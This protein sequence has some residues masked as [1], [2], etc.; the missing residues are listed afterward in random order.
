MSR[1]GLALAV[2]AALAALYVSRLD[3]TAG[4]YVDDAYYVVLAQAI[5]GGHGYTL[6]NSAVGPIL[7]A[8]PPGFALLLA[9][10][11]A[12]TAEF[13]RNIAALKMLSIVAMLGVAALTY[14]YL[15]D[16]R[17]L[18]RFRAAAIAVITAMLPAFVFLAT[19]TLMAECVFTLA[20]VASVVAI[21]RA[22]S[23]D[24]HTRGLIVAAVISTASWLVRSAGIAAVITGVVVLLWRRGW[25][26]SAAFLAVCVLCYAPWAIY[27]RV[28]E[29]TE[30]Q[31]AAYGGSIAY[32]Y[33][34]LLSMR[35]GGDAAGGS[36]DGGDLAARILKNAV[37]VFGR[38]FGAIFLPSGYRGAGESGQEVF[39]L[40]GES[41]LRSGSMGLGTTVLV[42][43]SMLSAFAL[44]GWAV[45]ASRRLG[46]AEVVTVVT[47]AMVLLIPNRTFRYVLPIAPFLLSYF[48][49]GIETVAGRFRSGLGFPAF[50]IAAATM[51]ILLIV[52]HG[53]YV[54][55]KVIGPESTWIE[56][57]H[58]V[59]AVTDWVNT[60][61]PVGGSVASTNPGLTYLLT[62][63]RTVAFVDPV[64]NWQRWKDSDIRYA[65]ALH[66]TPRPGPRHGYRF[67]YESP[68]LGLWVLEIAPKTR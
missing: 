42:M 7:P 52:E 40:S 26:A 66:V 21:D 64:Q 20:L 41:G 1:R 19:S 10:V 14:R 11:I 60:H 56:S 50:R 43:S 31:R 13:P 44:I 28:H 16:H 45:T 3:D 63:R 68:R 36:A 39:Q 38:D 33:S 8:F 32:S 9:P 49:A 65:I 37:N 30:A 4:L 34:A 35:Y 62:G 55:Q 15:L 67:L 6:I 46:A 18:D 23:S 12:V 59:R 29:P 25:R 57:G 58:E 5:A 48:L 22:A 17:G 53:Q 54:A 47:I 51:F 61:L 24:R 27:Q 2:G